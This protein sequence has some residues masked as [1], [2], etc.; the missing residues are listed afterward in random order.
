MTDYSQT[1][2]PLGTAQMT[3]RCWWAHH[4]VA[5]WGAID[6]VRACANAL[7]GPVEYDGAGAVMEALLRR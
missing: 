1:E 3:W 5:M 7:T 6:E 2:L 4:S